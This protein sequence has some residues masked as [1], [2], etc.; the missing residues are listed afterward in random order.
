MKKLALLIVVLLAAPVVAQDRP[1]SGT[2]VQ[3]T[4]TT[5]NSLLVGCA[6][7]STTC[8][9]GIK[10]G[11]IVPSQVT[12][13]GV[14]IIATDGRIPAISSTYFASLSGANITGVAL[15]SALNTFTGATNAFSVGAT[16]AVTL[17]IRNTTAGSANYGIMQVGNDGNAG[18]AS[19]YAFS[20]TFASSGA[21][22]ANG[23]LLQANG[24]GGLTFQAQDAAGI[25]R[26]FTGGSSQRWG[27][28][29][30]GD[31]TFGTSGNIAFSN[32]T[33]SIASGFGTSPAIVGN[34][35]AFRV[36][37]GT[38]PANGTVNFGHTW[39]NIPSCS[40]GLVSTLGSVVM[41]NPTTSAIGITFAT[42]GNIVAGEL[43]YVHCSGR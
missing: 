20:S 37:M 3:T 24:A 9:G 4:D 8:T 33:P 40:V 21:N 31:F 38:T 43:I 25:I 18:L 16:G 11:P 13:N 7:G 28:N 1:I 26:F 19:L 12:V 27:I 17:S 36:T 14:G 39:S 5:A 30:A 10:S 42:I 15:L 32:G 34:D 2:T 6:I 23:T 35:Y 41:I 22:F 29:A